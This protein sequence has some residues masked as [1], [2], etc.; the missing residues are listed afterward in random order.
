[1][2]FPR[3]WNQRPHCG[4]YSGVQLFRSILLTCVCALM[5]RMPV[6]AC[7]WDKPIWSKDKLSDTPLF[8]FVIDGKAGYINASGKVVI[9]ARFPIFDNRGYDDFYE[10]IANVLGLNNIDTGGIAVDFSP[11]ETSGFSHFS[12]GLIPAAVVSGKKWKWGFADH[13]GRLLIAAEFDGVHDFSEE[14]T[15]VLVGPRWGYIDHSG[16]LVIPHR[17]LW[18]GAFASGAARVVEDGPC[19][20][21]GYGPCDFANP[22]ILGFHVYKSG[23][24]PLYGRCMY[25]FVD[26]RGNALFPQRFPDAFDFAEGLAAVGDGKLWG[27]IDKAGAVRIPLKFEQVGS[28]SEG[29]ASFRQGRDWGYIDKSGRIAIQAQFGLVEDFSDGAAVVGIRNER[30]WFIDKSGNKL[31]GKDYRAASSFRLGL[32]HVSDGL[33]FAYIDRAGRTVF[34]YRSASQH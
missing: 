26:R 1:M 11:F 14:L 30:V 31:F 21:V 8:R 16:T 33:D 32:A 24:D 20:F 19:N 12:E 28:F 4:F 9:P 7:R 13:Y 6:T 3:D 10:G 5:V 18:A 17:F 2:I 22:T 29:L 23:R 27:F 34:S 15:A 25:A